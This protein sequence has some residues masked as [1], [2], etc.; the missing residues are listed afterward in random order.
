MRQI[1][2]TARTRGIPQLPPGADLA[3]NSPAVRSSA[4]A[5]LNTS[6][7][8][9]TLPTGTIAGD[10][11]V[12]FI[13]HA[14]YPSDPSGWTVH[15][16][17][18]G[19][20]FCIGG[21]WSKVMSSGDIT[22]GSVSVSFGGSYNGVICL[23]T[24]VGPTFGVRE[25][26]TRVNAGNG[27]ATLSSAVLDSDTAVYFCSGRGNS[28]NTVARGTQLQTASGS[29]ASGSVY[30]EDLAASGTYTAGF[31]HSVA[32]SGQFDAA[33]ILKGAA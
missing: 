23:V 33:I 28:T 5:L 20:S 19:G 6:T 7:M 14:Y 17:G 2:S 21:V 15:Y 32:G 12:L 8:T 18:T 9:L 30:S 11:V 16:N 25:T 4:L 31:T 27:D 1:L 13:E 29:E 10:R 3:I 26:V 22:T 24:F